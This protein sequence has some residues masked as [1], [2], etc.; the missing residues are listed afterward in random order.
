MTLLE[1]RPAE[2]PSAGARPD[3][4]S[5]LRAFG[6]AIASGLVLVGLYLVFVRTTEGQQLDEVARDH[7]GGSTA[8]RETVWTV[9]DI[10]TIGA[11]ALVLAACVLIA[12]ARRRW[13]LAVGAVVLV[14]T[15]NLATEVLKRQILTRPDLGYGQLNSFPSGHTTVVAS[16][17]MAA[18]LVVPRGARWLV[19]VVGSV[20]VAVTGVGTVV[21]GWHRPADVVAALFVSLAVG[22]AVLAVLTVRHGTQAGAPPARRNLA[23]VAA[24]PVAAAVFIALGIRPDGTVTDLLL[25]IAVMGALATVTAGLLALYARLVDTRFS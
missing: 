1:R 15:A 10:I 6:V 25:H 17:T 14:G 21:A 20:S 8:S 23:V 19:A 16:I 12:L 22:T 4:R 3:P 9:L 24:L 7:L 2:P 5:A 11:M 13:S 18:L